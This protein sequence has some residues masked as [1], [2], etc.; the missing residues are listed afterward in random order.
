MADFMRLWESQHDKLAQD[1]YA[2]KAIAEENRQLEHNAAILIQSVYRGHVDRSRIRFLNGQAKL[3]AV[4]YR[5]YR[6]RVNYRTMQIKTLKQRRE[7]AYNDGAT[8]LQA[9]WRGY[10]SRK[11]IKDMGVRKTFISSVSAGCTMMK[12]QITKY[13]EHSKEWVAEQEREKVAL[14]YQRRVDR[15]HHM[16]STITKPGVYAK[17]RTPQVKEKDL[18][19]SVKGLSE[20]RGRSPNRGRSSPKRPSATAS[21]VSTGTLLRQQGPF[22]SPEQVWTQRNKPLRPTLRVQT[23]FEHNTK[24]DRAHKDAEYLGRLHDVTFT[25]VSKHPRP[26]A[27]YNKNLVGSTPFK[28][29][30]EPSFRETAADVSFTTT[31]KAVTLFDDLN[32]NY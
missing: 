17:V 31:V 3:I 27:K 6:D 26:F 10:K 14:A 1:Y 30:E 15:E 13:V 24:A 21:L 12:T 28:D 32:Q 7:K 5:L 16:L 25:P 19:E 20:T 29:H 18:I 9:L 23:D 22:R 8:K 11:H 2:S 4:T